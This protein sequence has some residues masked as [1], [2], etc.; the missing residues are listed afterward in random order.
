MGVLP[1]VGEPT[2]VAR[3]GWWRWGWGVTSGGARAKR[4]KDSK[5]SCFLTVEDDDGDGAATDDADD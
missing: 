5:V 3:W 2:P 4:S 1:V